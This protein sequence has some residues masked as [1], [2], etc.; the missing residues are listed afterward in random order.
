MMNFQRYEAMDYVGFVGG[1]DVCFLVKYPV[2]EY[3]SWAVF[4]PF[5]ATV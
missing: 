3:S 4:L 2:A 1:D 5:T